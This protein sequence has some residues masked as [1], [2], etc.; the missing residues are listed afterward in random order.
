MSNPEAI[1]AELAAKGAAIND[2][3]RR[4]ARTVTEIIL[5]RVVYGFQ[6]GASEAVPVFSINDGIGEILAANKARQQSESWAGPNIPAKFTS[7]NFGVLTRLPVEYVSRDEV[8]MPGNSRPGL[9][10]ETLPEHLVMEPGTNRRATF[11]SDDIENRHPIDWHR[12]ASAARETMPSMVALRLH[13]NPYHGA[14]DTRAAVLAYRTWEVLKRDREVQFTAIVNDVVTMAGLDGVDG[15]DAM[16][17]RD[18]LRDLALF[19]LCNRYKSK[20][21]KVVFVLD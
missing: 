18:V 11:S 10:E 5:D 6:F 21:D 1:L 19:G 17:V 2:R 15:D 9:A 3:R 14:R 12:P 4:A 16:I 8:I 20:T 7:T 13:G